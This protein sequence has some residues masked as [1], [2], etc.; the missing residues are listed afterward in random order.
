MKISLQKLVLYCLCKQV[1]TKVNLPKKH[2]ITLQT[3]VQ[4]IVNF[5][6]VSIPAAIVKRVLIVGTTW[7]TQAYK[8]FHCPICMKESVPWDPYHILRLLKH[9]P[10]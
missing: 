1:G 10:T 4:V 5:D 9:L 7:R 6:E 3:E 8:H 2:T